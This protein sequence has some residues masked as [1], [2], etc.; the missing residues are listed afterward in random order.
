MTL[1]PP[2]KS[3]SC[4]MAGEAGQLVWPEPLLPPRAKPY[5]LV[6]P[7][8][9]DPEGLWVC[10]QGLVSS[11]VRPSWSLEVSRSWCYLSR[12]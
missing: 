3:S 9:A 1:C 12:R 2:L 7:R 10:K 6:I 8:R 5:L 4:E 11:T